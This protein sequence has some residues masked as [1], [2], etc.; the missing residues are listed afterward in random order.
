M[1]RVQLYEST[2]DT[3]SFLAKEAST[4]AKAKSIARQA[5][6]LTPAGSVFPYA[7]ILITKNSKVIEGWFSKRGGGW[8]HK[9]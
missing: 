8:L 6:N 4:L 9:K 5:K 7:L 2:K 1:Y 3:K